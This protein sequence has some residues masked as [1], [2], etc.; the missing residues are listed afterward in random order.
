MRKILRKRLSQI[1]FL[2]PTF[3]FHPIVERICG[4][5]NVTSLPC[6]SL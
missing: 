4:R 3:H 2:L 1:L 5:S 6:M